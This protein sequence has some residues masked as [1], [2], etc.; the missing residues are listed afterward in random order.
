VVVAL[1]AEML[2][3]VEVLVLLEVVRS[4]G[5]VLL[6]VVL[7]VGVAQGGLLPHLSAAMEISTQTS[8][9]MEPISVDRAVNQ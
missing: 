5:V 1:L 8:N 3:A 2:S 4:V 7:S 9:A 6:G